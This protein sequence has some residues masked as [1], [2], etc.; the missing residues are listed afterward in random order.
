MCTGECGPN[1]LSLVQKKAGWS[2][3][4]ETEL[5]ETM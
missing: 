5:N 1:L 4:K 2:D 3:E